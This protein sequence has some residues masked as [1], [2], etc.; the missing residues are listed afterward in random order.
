[1]SITADEVEEMLEFYHRKVWDKLDDPTYV[2]DQPN[3]HKAVRWRQV[4]S[5]PGHP[6]V[7]A[8]QPPRSPDFNRPVEH[9]H[10]AL[11]REFRESLR[12]VEVERTLQGYWDL[13]QQCAKR[14]YS[15]DAVRRDVEGLPDLWEW[16]ASEDPQHGS[17]GDWPPRRLR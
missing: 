11:K 10:S 3:I 5:D 15:Q 14:C 17:A 1:M 7:P 8:E 13:L 12:H 16:I 4:Y 6:V 9:F 2:L